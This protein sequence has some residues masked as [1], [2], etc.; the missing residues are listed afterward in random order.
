MSSETLQ[1]MAPNFGKSEKLSRIRICSYPKFGSL[2][3]CFP[4]TSI[5]V[6]TKPSSAWQNSLSQGQSGYTVSNERT[7]YSTP[8]SGAGRSLTSCQSVLLAAL[9]GNFDRQP[10]IRDQIEPD[11]GVG[12]YHFN[13]AEM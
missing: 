7:E 1:L 4:V 10:W 5:G 3:F 6:L 12:M 8:L 9:G 11:G 2:R 13:I